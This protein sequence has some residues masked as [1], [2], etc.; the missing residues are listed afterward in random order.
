MPSLFGTLFLA[1]LEPILV[2]CLGLLRR[3]DADLVVFSAKIAFPIGDWVDV[4][5]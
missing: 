4:K 3:Y 5:S 2:E 1:L